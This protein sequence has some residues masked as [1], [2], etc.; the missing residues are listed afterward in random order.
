[1]WDVIAEFGKQ[2]WDNTAFLVKH[3][4]CSASFL[5]S[6]NISDA[7]EQHWYLSLR[8]TCSWSGLSTLMVEMMLN[9]TD[10]LMTF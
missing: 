5:D 7:A 6:V 10:E 2:I 9:D 8:A 3:W 1:M 4:R